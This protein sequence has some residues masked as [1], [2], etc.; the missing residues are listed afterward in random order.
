[1]VGLE[2]QG[3]PQLCGC[4]RRDDISEPDIKTRGLKKDLF[5]FDSS[6]S[7]KSLIRAIKPW[8][9]CEYM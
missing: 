5:T 8:K 1:M 9:V 6:L 7:L 2:G 3:R 4:Q